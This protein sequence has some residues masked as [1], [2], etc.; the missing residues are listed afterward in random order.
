M[1]TKHACTWLVVTWKLS[2]VITIHFQGIS[3]Y[4]HTRLVI[5]K[6]KRR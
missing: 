4:V 2:G 6:A 3:T 1:K 5:L